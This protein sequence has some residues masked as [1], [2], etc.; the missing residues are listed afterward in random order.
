MS[1]SK[2]AALLV[3][4]C[5]FSQF[6]ASIDIEDDESVLC[7]MFKDITISDN[8]NG[9]ANGHP[10]NWTFIFCGF[11]GEKITG[12]SAYLYAATTDTKLNTTYW[13]AELEFL[14]FSDASF[15]GSIV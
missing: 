13:P 4:L 6:S 8:Y 10:C 5:A 2:K 1:W 12:L 9:V 3:F 11:T 14:Y 15:S 7:N